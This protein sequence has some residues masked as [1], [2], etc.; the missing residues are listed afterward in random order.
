[1]V[2]ADKGPGRRRAERTRELATGRERIVRKGA[3]G[4]PRDRI[5]SWGEEVL[6]HEARAAAL[7]G[8]L[9]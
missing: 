5:W 3:R 8:S 4:K 6:R 9:N 1:M 2:S 7:R